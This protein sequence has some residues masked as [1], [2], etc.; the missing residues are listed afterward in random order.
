MVA[1]RLHAATVPD[2]PDFPIPPSPAFHAAAAPG[3]TGPAHP[4]AV[5]ADGVVRGR[6]LLEDRGAGRRHGGAGAGAGALGTRGHPGDA[7]LPRHRGG[8]APGRAAGAGAGRDPAGGRALRGGRGAAGAHPLCRPPAVV[9]SRE[10]LRRRLDRLSRQRPALRPAQPGGA[11]LRGPARPAVGR[12]C[13]RLADGPGAA[14]SGAGRG[15]AGAARRGAGGLHDPQ[16]GVP[17]AVSGRNAPPCRRR[18]SPFHHRRSRVPG[19][20]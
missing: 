16:S 20:S 13:A 1:A 3:R 7:A 11:R 12:P 10:P 6:P 14:L 19:G 15:R 5:G 17:G 9:R 2:A 8:G 18:P 4:R